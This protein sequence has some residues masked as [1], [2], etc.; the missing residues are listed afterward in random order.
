MSA[1]ERAGELGGRLRDAA[2]DTDGAAD[3]IAAAANLLAAVAEAIEELPGIRRDLAILLRRGGVAV[4][5]IA[6]LAA[7]TPSRVSQIVG[8]LD[9]LT[10]RRID[11]P[12]PPPAA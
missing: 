1:V 5:D 10:R 4:V 9:E 6:E 8:P 2:D 3:H 7:V 11:R 12:T